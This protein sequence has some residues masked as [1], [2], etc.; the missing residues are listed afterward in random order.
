MQSYYPLV[1]DHRAD[2]QVALSTLESRLI[3]AKENKKTL[4]I[5]VL[6]EKNSYDQCLMI[7]LGLLDF[8]QSGYI[9]SYKIINED[10]DFIKQPIYESRLE[11]NKPTVIFE[12]VDKDTTLIL[13]SCVTV[14]NIIEGVV[15][16][17]SEDSRM[18]AKELKNARIVHPSEILFPYSAKNVDIKYKEKICQK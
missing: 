12:K 8:Y 7:I 17:N 5:D 9:S 1:L 16:F 11:I 10:M 13:N 15:V 6:I 3:Q 2:F 18:I 14:L 4:I